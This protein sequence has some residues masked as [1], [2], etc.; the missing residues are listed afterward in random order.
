MNA[1]SQYIVH[2]CSRADWQAAREAGEYRAASLV[3]EGFIH[4]SRPEQI[5]FVANSFYRGE[6]DLVLLWID[7]AQAAAEI[8][9][10]TT[11]LGTFPHIY[12]P[13]NL[14]AV[15]AVRDFLPDA[16]GEFQEVPEA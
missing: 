15:L 16:H 8:R 12:G 7:P 4:C 14:E 10:D 11:E 3:E 2:L 1:S 13:L 9:W 5:L 6:P